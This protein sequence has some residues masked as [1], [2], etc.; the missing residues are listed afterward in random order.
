MKKILSVL[1]ILFPIFGWAQS[2]QVES[3]GMA[4]LDLS[5]STNQRNDFNVT[6]PGTLHEINMTVQ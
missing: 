2:M 5:A 1:F 6:S 3:M 4:P